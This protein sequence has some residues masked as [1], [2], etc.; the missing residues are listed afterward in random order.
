MPTRNRHSYSATRLRTTHGNVSGPS[1]F[2]TGYIRI[3]TGQ[4]AAFPLTVFACFSACG[5]CFRHIP[6]DGSRRASDPK[7]ET[8]TVIRPVRRIYTLGKPNDRQRSRPR[9]A[10]NPTRFA[11]S[12]PRG[13]PRKS[14]V[15]RTVCTS[16]DGSAQNES[17]KNRPDVRSHG[18][19]RTRFEYDCLNSTP[20]QKRRI[21]RTA[22]H[23]KPPGSRHQMESIFSILSNSRLTGFWFLIA[24]LNGI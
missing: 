15:C 2:P 9:Q 17:G 12:L 7:Q 18:S 13:I 8:T 1:G 22:R 20:A 10:P 23:T 24:L 21:H 4:P 6:N 19:F 5:R 11:A 3:R 16:P 14:P